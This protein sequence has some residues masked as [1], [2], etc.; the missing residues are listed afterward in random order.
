MTDN[1]PVKKNSVYKLRILGEGYEGEG[2]AKIDSYPIFVPNAILGEEVE[3]LIV[4]VGKAF[5]YG[6]AVKI[7]EES[8]ER[9]KAVCQSFNSCGGCSLMFMSYEHQ[10]E[11]KRRQVESSLKRIGGFSGVLVCPT[12]GM[13]NPFRYRNKIQI[14]IG[15]SIGFFSKRSHKIVEVKNCFIQCDEGDIIIDV[16]KTWIGKFNIKCYDENTHKGDI[17]HLVIRKGFNTNQI[18]V[19]I[20]CNSTDIDYKDDF[21]K[22]ILDRLPNVKSIYLNINMNKTNVILGDKSVLIYGVK[23]IKERL[24]DLYFN[25]SCETFFQVNTI[26][27][28][29]LYNKVLEYADLTKDDV[30]FDAYC[31]VG[32]ISLF[33][34]KVSKFVYGIEIVEKSVEDALDN[35]LENNIKNVDFIAGSCGEKI[36]ELIDKGIS[37]DC[38]VLDPPRKGV[39]EGVIK[40]IGRNKPKKIVYVS[41]NP[42]TLSRDLKLICEFGY[43]IDKVQPVD[44]FPMTYHVE[45]VVLLKMH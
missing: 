1:I 39:E 4:K 7:I 34:A 18:M 42:A 23:A 2:V 8:P 5:S 32:S 41:C 13:K 35:A 22:M 29:V 33:L 19:I 15:E 27:A 11:F 17:R 24:F 21:I 10:L 37:C 20:V 28:E 9:V 12:L 25:I 14:P 38:L 36:N 40:S 31:G 16:F 6:K 26:Q 3:V 43:N 45:T 30:V 44:M